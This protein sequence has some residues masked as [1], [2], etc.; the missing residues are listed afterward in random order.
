L[1][2]SGLHWSI[3]GVQ[4]L[5]DASESAPQAVDNQALSA[6]MDVPLPS[7]SMTATLRRRSLLALTALLC[8]ASPPT[9]AAQSPLSTAI[10]RVEQL[11]AQE[12][13]KDPRGSLTIGV[14]SRDRLVWSK[15]YGEADVERK[16]AAT[17][18]SIYRIGSIT[19]QFTGLMLLQLVD[20]GKV[21]LTD[22]VEKHLPEI[23]KL[24]GR[25]SGWPAVTLLQLATMTAG[26]AR[27][28]EDLPTFLVGPV[29]SWEQTTIKAIERTSYA[30]EPGTRYLYSN[31]GYAILG[32]AL[33]RAAG[34]PYTEY[35]REEILT[36]LGMTQTFFE[37][38]ASLA[39]RIVKGYAIRNNELDGTAPEREHAGRG[40]KV[41][42]GALYTTAGDLAKFLAFE[43]GHGP[44]TVLSV[45]ARDENYSRLSSASGDLDSGY[46]VGFQATRRGTH[47]FLGHGG[48]V[49]G[50]NAAAHIHRPSQTGVIVFRNVGG[51]PVSAGGLAL[52]S[53]EILAATRPTS[54]QEE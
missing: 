33:S 12:F 9:P 10:E 4:S 32:A 13:A 14:V 11:A 30:H 38:N 47:V 52:R 54:D 1:K 17:P 18:E 5:F 24:Q 46:G 35:V 53:L 49:A 26:I 21:R 48:S 41:P 45:K 16:I 31:I 34:R 42:N 51:G 50:Y 43:L 19:K 25:Q 29:A 28:P 7:S 6:K 22:P 23:N 27:E 39:A 37:P 20:R 2:I 40:Y 36:P 15:S 44:D 8:A 3:R